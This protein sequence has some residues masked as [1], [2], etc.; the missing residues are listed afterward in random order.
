MPMAAETLEATP[1]PCEP[2][3]EAMRTGFIDMIDDE[4]FLASREVSGPV[5]CVLYGPAITHCPFCGT[6]LYQPAKL[7]R[8][9]K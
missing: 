6:Q 9:E 5:H 7:P 8:A 4:I 1:C 2:F 3:A